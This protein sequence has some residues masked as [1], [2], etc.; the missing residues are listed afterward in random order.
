MGKFTSS[1]KDPRGGHA[2]LYW[3]I[4]DSNAWRCL[5]ATD[6]RAYVALLRQLRSFNNGDLSLPLSAAKPHG[7]TSPATLAKSLRSLVAVGLIAVT[8]K[9]GCTRGGQRLPTLYRLTDYQV[10]ES[11]ENRNKFIEPSKVTDDWKTIK[12]LGQGREAIRLAEATAAKT[13]LQKLIATTSKNEAVERLTAS[14]NEVWAPFHTSNIEVGEK[15][16]NGL[17]ANSGEG[18]QKKAS[19]NSL[20]VHTSNIEALCIVATPIDE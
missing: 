4:L 12:T 8:R 16:K 20:E 3:D 11:G 6:Q 1:P 5:S 10:Y 15:C 13:Q 7:I 9:G 14:K 18:L 19:D 17:K 2:R